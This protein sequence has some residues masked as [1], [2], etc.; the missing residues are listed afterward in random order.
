MPQ[1]SFEQLK[2]SKKIWGAHSAPQTPSW[3][4]RL[5]KASLGIV[6]RNFQTFFFLS[7]D[8]SASRAASSVDE[9]FLNPYCCEHNR[10]LE[11]K[12]SHN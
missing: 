1:N 12:Y 10:F 3:V 7:V 4:T 8:M 2:M 9:F 11:E 5:A 6:I